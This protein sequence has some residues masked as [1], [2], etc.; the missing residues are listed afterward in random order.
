M[1]DMGEPAWRA[2]A[3]E[4]RKT[5][6]EL[7]PPEWRLKSIPDFTSSIPVIESSGILTPLELEITNT[8]NASTLSIKIQSR[9]W[10]SE[11]IT[12]AF[13]KRAAIAQ[14][15]TGCCTE[16]IFDAAIKQAKQQ[17]EH[18]KSTGNLVGPLHG[19]PLS[20]KDSHEIAGVDTTVGWVGLINKPAE[21]DN[22]AVSQYRS[23][24]AILYCKTNIPQ[25]L[26]MSDSYNHIF[27]QSVNSLNRNLIS[28][29]SSGGEGAILGARA[30]II[31]IGT[32]IGGSIRI[33][34]V[35]QGLY[36]LCPTIG[37]IPNRDSGRA[38]KYVVPP[39]AGPMAT[40][41]ASIELFMESYS[42]I[43]PWTTDPQIFPIHWRTELAVPPRRPLKIG[44]ILDD[45]VVRC[46]PPIQR[47]MQEMIAKLKTAGH[48]IFEWNSSS[49]RYAY[50]DLWLKAVLAD[51]GQRCAD[52]CK[53]VDEP[54]I[55]GMLV[56]KAEDILSV[57]ERQALAE[58]IWDYQSNYLKRWKETDIDGILMPVIPWVGMKPKTWV[59]SQ[60]YC[61]Y[62]AIWNLLNYTALAIPAGVV[63]RKLDVPDEAWKTYEGNGFSDQFNHG[64]YDLDMV[65][66]MPVGLQIVTGRFGEERSVAI[67]KVIDE[68]R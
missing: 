50:F 32:D 27:G 17:D 7:V 19:I 42:S 68:L 43:S 11:Q 31:G 12:T 56:G 1:G 55:P 67:A 53:L 59:Q 39:V 52:L 36:G 25:S 23:L 51:G 35:L 44:Y 34:A 61:G 48:D 15:L 9:T 21:K 45:G 41:L 24:G 2:T 38:Q 62:T 40:S 30:S 37:R 6:A 28:G 46:H 20:L 18:L 49:H 14:Q 4:R 57:P 22:T 65:E 66:G 8:T 10:T 63:D 64:L 3:R 13:C 5:Q 33:P 16:M 54:L 58:K 47:A 29:G 26:M 60:Q